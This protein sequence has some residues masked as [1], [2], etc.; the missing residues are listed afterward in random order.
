[1]STRPKTRSSPEE[2]AWL[3]AYNQIQS[4]RGMSKLEF[5]AGFGAAA[6]YAEAGALTGWL[7]GAAAR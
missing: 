6:Q 1:M 2:R 7:L 3:A 5:L 4:R